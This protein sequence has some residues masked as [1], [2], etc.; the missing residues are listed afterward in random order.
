M[1]SDWRFAPGHATNPAQDFGH[2][3]A[4]FTHFAKAGYGDGPASTN[5]DDRAWRVI[6][7]PH[8]WCV[9]LNFNPKGGHSHGYK[10]IGHNFPENSIGWYRK[11]F[12]I[13]ESD[14]G[15]KISIQF[16]GVHRNSSVFVNG[17]YLGEENSGYIS[18]SYDMTD[19]LNYG[20][21]NII[22]VRVDASVEEGWFYEGAGIYR[23]VWL[24][25]TNPLHIAE[26]GTFITTKNI[27]DQT[28][29][30]IR[31]TIENE[32]D[33]ELE[34]EIEET[35]VNPD[36]I[37]ISRNKLENLSL[38]CNDQKEYITKHKIINP[39]IWS[40]EKPYLHKLYTKIMENNRVIDHYE[41]TFGIRTVR[42][43]PDSGF[44]LNDKH[45]KIKGTNNHQDHAGVGTA[46]PD[47]LQEFRV[48]RLLEMGSNA[49]RTSH[50]P[51]TPELL[52]VCDRL[53]MLVMDENRLM[54]TNKEHFYCLE[55]LIKR[56]RNHPSVV[57]WS[58]GNE[59]WAIEGNEK[60][61]RITETMQTFANRLDSSRAFTVA[62]SG[63]W[64]TGIGAVSQVMGYNY[65][66]HGDID[67]HH[68]KF[69][70]QPAVGTEES[71]LS[72]TRGIYITDMKNAHQA[73]NSFLSESGGIENGWKFYYERP[74]LAGLFYWTGFDY[75]GE[76]NPYGWPQVTSQFGILD[77]CGFPKDYFYY[78][79]AW[80]GNE[81]A[82]YIS[83]HWNWDGKEGQNVKV[84]VYSNLDEV[85]LY[86]NNRSFGKKQVLL[87]SSQYWQ[88]VFEPGILE[89]VGF[90]DG[91]KVLR[92]QRRTTGNPVAIQL[93]ADRNQIKADGKDV[94]VITIQVIDENGLIIPTADHE[95]FFALEGTGKILGVGNGNP[96]SHEPDKFLSKIEVCKIENLKELTI[97]VLDNR[98]EVSAEYDDSGWISA[99]SNEPEDWQEYRDSLIVIRGSF[100]L[101]E[102]Q[103]KDTVNLFTKSI[104]ENQSIYINGQLIKAHIVRDD[105]NQSFLL[106]HR[107]LKTGKN[108]YAVTG[109]RFRLRHKWDE[110][111]RDPGLVQIIRPAE[112]WRRKVFNGLAQLII[113]SGQKKDILILRAFSPGLNST[114][115]KITTKM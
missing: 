111:N 24:I 60:G 36:G 50:N 44:F 77:L 73:P 82:L 89:A 27:N 105:P 20:G 46:I 23:H 81:P 49:I 70:W 90:K 53:G 22:A 94:S 62:S 30:K 54:G 10:E 39:K 48:K 64:D 113:Q 76:P 66:F 34:F 61:I 86:L 112:Q 85:E 100:D 9:E 63:G 47:A 55:R 45:I 79:Q 6:N 96:S 68:K 18:F 38:M 52:D 98:K 26:Y 56:D 41:T 109:K 103:F 78:L 97:D 104:V 51:P 11:S 84:I 21:D 115:L 33:K 75:R 83:P 19:Y 58:L 25:K 5:F 43:D 92:N 106:S 99:F 67:A 57:I 80:W 107:F 59:E 42:F 72:G 8:D 4:Y 15:K 108:D 12:F 93:I 16:D 14:F 65:I 88:V 69:P 110:P 40:L 74:F 2:S 37:I 31:T 91:I 1:D 29:I 13:A 7:L 32:F 71:T 87:N 95:I 17:F 114:G 101:P 35:I 28:I 102:I 3:T